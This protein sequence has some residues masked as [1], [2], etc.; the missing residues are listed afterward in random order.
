MDA[1]DKRAKDKR[2][3]KRSRGTRVSVDELVAK[4]HSVF[5]G[6]GP[7]VERVKQRLRRFTR[8]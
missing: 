7:L 3:A 4:S 8:T 6:V 5:D 2:L 1:N